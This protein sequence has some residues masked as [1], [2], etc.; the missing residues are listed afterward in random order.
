[1]AMCTCVLVYLLL[2]VRFYALPST[3]ASSA[4]RT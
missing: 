4:M 2:Y 1:M 3:I